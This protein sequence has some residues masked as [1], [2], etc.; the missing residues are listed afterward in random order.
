MLRLEANRR[1]L[2]DHALMI[3]AKPVQMPVEGGGGEAA[4]VE[5]DEPVRGVDRVLL[6]KFQNAHRRKMAAFSGWW[7]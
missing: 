4:L 2:S 1:R 6:Q 3:I 7:F 5:L